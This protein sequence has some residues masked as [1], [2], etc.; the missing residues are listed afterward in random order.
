[1]DHRSSGK[2]D[3]CL[4]PSESVI[5]FQT[6]TPSVPIKACAALLHKDASAIISRKATRPSELVKAG[7]YASYG[8]CSSLFNII[9][10]IFNRDISLRCLLL[11]DGGNVSGARYED[12]IVQAMIDRDAGGKGIAGQLKTTTPAKCVHKG[13][14]KSMI[15]A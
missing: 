9:P 11:T 2:V 14:F 13:A 3:F 15:G 4:C 12:A 6:T 8:Q 5:S 10:K 1:M 7:T